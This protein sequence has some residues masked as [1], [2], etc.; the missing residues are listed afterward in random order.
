MVANNHLGSMLLHTTSDNK[1]LLAFGIVIMLFTCIECKTSTIWKHNIVLEFIYP[2]VDFMFLISKQILS[3]KSIY[4]LY[5]LEL[6]SIYLNYVIYYKISRVYYKKCFRTKISFK[7]L[8]NNEKLGKYNICRLSW[9]Y[10]QV[11]QVNITHYF[12]Y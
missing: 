8:L 6:I 4:W 1:I 2:M 11:L 10:E 7:N 3:L 9:Y 5:V 12:P